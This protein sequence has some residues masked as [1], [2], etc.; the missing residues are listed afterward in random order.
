MEIDRCTKE[1]FDRIL[2]EI[3]LFWGS[4]RTLALH[5]PLFLYEWGETAFVIR[6]RGKVDAYLFGF[7]AQSPEGERLAYTHLLAVRHS[8]RRRGLARR[9]YAHFVRIAVESGCTRLKAITTAD[10]T[11]S[12]R[13]HTALGM[14]MLGT[15]NADGVPVVADYSGPGLDRVVS[16]MRLRASM[17]LG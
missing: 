12:I 5:H 15:P 9:L 14:E 7:T 16:S 17:R 11:A 6:D 1:D 10:N 4:D 8:R 3:A 2:T 13:C